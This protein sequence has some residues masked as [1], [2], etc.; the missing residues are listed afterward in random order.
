MASR[1][2]EAQRLA[3]VGSWEWD[4]IKDVVTWSDELYRIYGLSRGQFLGTFADFLA[5]VHPEDR[6]LTTEVL[7]AAFRDPKPFAFDHRVLRGDGSVRMLQTRGDVVRDR[8]GAVVRMVGCCVDVTERWEAVR[9]LQDS[10]SML[11][12]TLESTADGI[13]VMDLDG[14][15]VASNERALRLWGLP[16][17]LAAQGDLNAM[18]AYVRDQLE[19]WKAFE[20]RER[21]LMADKDYAGLDEIRFKDGRIYERYTQPQRIGNVTIGRVCSFRDVTEQRRTQEDLKRMMSELEERVRQR[22]IDL[23]NSN[24]ELEM[25]A[26]AAS[27]DLGA[28]LRKILAFLSL[29]EKRLG[30]KLTPEESKLLEPIRRAATGM[31][32]LLSDVLELSRVSRKD[33][34]I[35]PVD[36]NAVLAEIKADLEVMM[37]ESGAVVESAGLPTVRA[38]V[39][40]MRRL[41][42]NLVSNAIKFRGDRPPRVVIGAKR[43][44]GHWEVS[45]RDNGIGF[46]LKY[47]RSIFQPFSRL[48]PIGTYQGSGIGL[49]ICKRIVQ[50]Y[51]AEILV[52]SIP[53]R[54][55]VF[56][57]RFPP[58]MIVAS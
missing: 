25:F 18:L 50:R 36:L 53:G 56:T 17:S 52:D 11:R 21:E 45:V 13:F 41:F 54:G 48:N 27:H 9:H 51:G 43:D 24:A 28:P 10:L 58:E 32:K 6:A 35:E 2:A 37:A 42:Q 23:A 15:V 5:R 14:K 4:A 40:L 46:D 33:M 57:V 39:T 29:L 1:M 47:S 30:S 12:A 19:E 7:G 8:E 44:N 16:E 26:F 22:T 38:H 20:R 3:H 31:S 49:T 34:P 55:S